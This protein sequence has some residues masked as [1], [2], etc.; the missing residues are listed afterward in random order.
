MVAVGGARSPDNFAGCLVVVHNLL[1]CMPVG[2]NIEHLA[3]A[4]R[5]WCLDNRPRAGNWELA[6]SV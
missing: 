2:V 3:V 4:G 5:C 6:G 1:G